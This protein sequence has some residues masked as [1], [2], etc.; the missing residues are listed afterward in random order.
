M[1]N[2]LIR[3]LGRRDY[4]KVYADMQQFTQRRDA[5]TAD[6][7]WIVE[8]DPVFTLGQAAKPEHLLAPG[9][10][11]VVTTD[12]GGEVTYHGPG[13]LV[14]YPL[15]DLGRRQIGPRRLVSGIEQ[16]LIDWL[17][18]HGIEAQR[19]DGAPGVYV[20]GEKIASIGLRVRKPGCYHGLALNMDMDLEPFSRINPCG[21]SG[22]RMCQV[23]NWLQPTPSMETVGLDLARRL[24]SVLYSPSAQP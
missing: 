2:A 3:Q 19:K 15:L 18:E 17:D 12:R 13:Q 24:D 10:I 11:P 16:V 6:E 14:I 23:A 22:L 5:N 20:D 21:Y 8:H 7:I 1:N 4:A 9:A